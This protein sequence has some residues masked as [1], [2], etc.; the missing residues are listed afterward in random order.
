MAQAQGTCDARFQE[1]KTL[2]QS[3]LDS[4]DELGAS[5]CVNIDGEDVVDLWGG[6]ADQ[7]RT[8]P[9][10]ADTICTIWSTTKAITSLAA[11]V[12]I[13]RGLLS[14]HERV[15]HYWPEF[16]ANGKQDVLV[17][18]ILSHTA[19]LPAWDPPIASAD[20]YDLPKANA[21]LARQAPRWPPGSASGYHMVTIGHL[22]GELVFRT[23]GKR[24]AAF[25]ADE[26]AG[27]LGA[28]FQIGARERDW[29]RV[30]D[31]IPPPTP[32]SP[33]SPPPPEDQAGAE[34]GPP[35]PPPNDLVEK[36]K[37]AVWRRGELG[38]A[39]GHSNAKGV[40]RM[41]SALALDGEVGGVRL[42]SPATIALVFEEQANGIDLVTKLPIRFGM[43]FGLTGNDTF[44]G[45]FPA[46][47]QEEG[48]RVC[49]W[50]GWGGSIVI[51]DLERRMTVAYVMNKMEMTILGNDRTKAYVEAVYKGLRAA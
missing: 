38:A 22:V 41:L 47:A 3:Y 33:P 26:I 15:S 8:R 50:G 32:P 5:I 44:A 11:L 23:T 25:V 42:L 19:G 48:A 27:P 12:L 37:T 9:W 7:A 6:H 35:P 43:G 30:A 21:L 4:G 34:A 13:D 1:V 18:H 39:N 14:P 36:T 40:A 2:F 16:A 28:D 46:E 24:L 49:F 10:T 51:M 45:W 20:M 29:P 31:M 17:R